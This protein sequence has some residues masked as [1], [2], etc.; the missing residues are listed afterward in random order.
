MNC[1]HYTIPGTQPIRDLL[2]KLPGDTSERLNLRSA[3]HLSC[4]RILRESANRLHDSALPA[5]RRAEFV[6]AIDAVI[7]ELSHHERVRRDQDEYLSLRL[8]QAEA[9]CSLREFRDVGDTSGFDRLS[10][11]LMIGLGSSPSDTGEAEA[12]VRLI[13]RSPPPAT[14]SGPATGT[15][16]ASVGRLFGFLFLLALLV[17]GMI[18]TGLLGYGIGS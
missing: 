8:L 13:D 16:L 12:P 1:L 7:E 18:L 11:K 6:G 3:D 5:R 17:A 14:E 10:R 9:R 4:H 15:V 2:A